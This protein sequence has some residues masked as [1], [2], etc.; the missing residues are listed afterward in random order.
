[1]VV[2]YG[3]NGVPGGGDKDKGPGP[4][5]DFYGFPNDALFAKGDLYG[6]GADWTLKSVTATNPQARIDNNTMMGIMQS[7]ECKLS[8]PGYFGIYDDGSD[9]IF[10]K[11]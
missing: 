1:M 10:Y 9:D 2:S 5:G 8:K 4:A 3:P 11:F 7:L 6:T